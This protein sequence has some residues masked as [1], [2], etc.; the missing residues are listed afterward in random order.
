MSEASDFPLNGD[1]SALEECF[2]NIRNSDGFVLI[3][4]KRRGS[5]YE[6]GLSVTR[7]ELRVARESFLKI[8]KPYHH[9]FIS[10]GIQ[11]DL[12]QR[13]NSYL[14]D[15]GVQ[16]PEHLREFIKEI[17]QPE[18]KTLP[19]FL[20]EFASFDDIMD[21]INA[22]LNLGRNLAEYI[23]RKS[24]HVE[25]TR[26]LAMMVNRVGYPSCDWMISNL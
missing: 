13:E 7:Q 20:K 11:E 9:L 6:P 16:D 12:A 8:G 14:L 25:L 23:I 15:A 22:R 24:V 4:D 10:D 2:E 19:D 5:E 18:D 3:V 17:I 1:R 26:N 21:S